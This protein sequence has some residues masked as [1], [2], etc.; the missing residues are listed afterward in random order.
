[1]PG[2]IERNRKGELYGKRTHASSLRKG[3]GIVRKSGDP[4]QP[5]HGLFV[6]LPGAAP[7][8]KPEAARSAVFAAL[9]GLAEAGLATWNERCAI[10]S[11]CAV[12]AARSGCSTTLA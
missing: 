12:Y 9:G 7:L 4:D 3:M 2:G 8:S 1:M 11:N 5:G 10:E 6:A